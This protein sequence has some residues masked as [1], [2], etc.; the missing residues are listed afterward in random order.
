MM[1]SLNAL[2]ITYKTTWLATKWNG[3]LYMK[4]P[5]SVEPHNTLMKRLFRHPFVVTFLALGS[6][7][8]YSILHIFTIIK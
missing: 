7:H 8:I 1:V 4:M 6:F 3:L 2:L 5:L